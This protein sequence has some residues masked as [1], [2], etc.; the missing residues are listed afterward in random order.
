VADSGSHCKGSEEF[1]SLRSGD[2][3]IRRKHSNHIF[4]FVQHMYM[5]KSLAYA[6]LLI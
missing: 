1:S 6:K 4:S 5:T 2:S 3:A